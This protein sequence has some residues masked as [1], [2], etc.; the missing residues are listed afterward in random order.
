[1]HSWHDVKA[2]RVTPQQFLAMIEISKGSKNKY[3]LDKETGHL[4][5]DRVLFTSTQ[6][7]F[8]CGLSLLFPFVHS[9]ITE[10]K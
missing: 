5:L 1:M 2:N 6:Q 7:K 10:S 8:T 9:Y 3:E 4:I